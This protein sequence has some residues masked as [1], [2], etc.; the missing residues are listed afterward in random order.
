MLFALDADFTEEAFF[1]S[2]ETRHR[3]AVVDVGSTIRS[4]VL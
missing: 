4:F 3:A 1:E 2:R